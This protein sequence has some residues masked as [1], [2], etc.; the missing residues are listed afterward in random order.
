MFA[1]LGIA[2]ALGMPA[3]AHISYGGRDFGSYTGLAPDTD[4]I[5][6]QAIT[7]NYGWA[8]ATDAD[9]GDSHRSRAFRFHL[10]NAAWVTITAAANPTATGTSVGG[11]LPGFSVYGGLA[12]VAPAAADHDFSTQSQLYLAS[13]GGFQPKEGSWVALGDWRIGSDESMSFADLSTFSFMGYAVDGTA[14][15]FGAAPGVVGDGIADG[16]VKGSFLLG[17]GD[18]SIFVGGAD[19]AAQDPDNPSLLSP[20]GLSLTLSVAPVREPAGFGV[21][22]VGLVAVGAMRN[23]VCRAQAA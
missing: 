14:A 19:Y 5:S 1:I 16:L 9:F 20:Y 6:N 22:L 23:R 18:Y 7:S 13:L 10:D 2:M 4:T 8:D 15:N 12:H 17:P 3:H 11:L 21:I